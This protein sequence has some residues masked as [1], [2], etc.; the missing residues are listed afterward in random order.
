MGKHDEDRED[1]SLVDRFFYCFN[2]ISSI[3]GAI[4]LF[5]VIFY[6]MLYL[7]FRT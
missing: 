4:V 5:C 2:G 7:A 3:V 1:D 6:A